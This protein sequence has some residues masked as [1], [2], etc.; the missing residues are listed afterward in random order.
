MRSVHAVPHKWFG[1]EAL[2]FAQDLPHV[3]LLFRHH[4]SRALQSSQEPQVNAGSL[5]S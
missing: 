2:F 3:D 5:R 1:H 4:Y